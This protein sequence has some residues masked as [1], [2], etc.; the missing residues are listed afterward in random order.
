MSNFSRSRKVRRACRSSALHCHRTN[1]FATI[2]CRL[3]YPFQGINNL[4]A[5][6]IKHSIARSHRARRPY[7]SMCKMDGP[8]HLCRRRKTNSLM[9]WNTLK[10]EIC[11]KMRKTIAKLVTHLLCWSRAIWPTIIP[12]MS[13]HLRTTI[14]RGWLLKLCKSISQNRNSSHSVGLATTS[15]MCSLV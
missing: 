8:R 13:G 9:S 2:T 1:R 4:K 15:M 7:K 6:S 12:K 11:W 5:H 14:S 3:W 10:A